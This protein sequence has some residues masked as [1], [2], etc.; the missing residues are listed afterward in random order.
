MK[1]KK[2]GTDGNSV[3]SLKEVMVGFKPEFVGDIKDTAG[4]KYEKYDALPEFTGKYNSL[5]SKVLTKRLFEK[6]K[7]LKAAKGYTLSNC[8]QTGVK[9]PHLGVGITAGDEESWAMFKDT[10]YPVIKGWHGYDPEVGTRKRGLDPSKVVIT[11]EQAAKFDKYV[12][13][14]RARAARPRRT[15]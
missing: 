14:T 9:A 13:S 6:M 15:R 12:A 1:K 8:I 4:F 10:K 2:K 3:V 11:D 7:D 5:M